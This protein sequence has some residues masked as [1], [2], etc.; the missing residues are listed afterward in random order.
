MRSIRSAVRHYIITVI[1]VDVKTRYQVRNGI[2][3]ILPDFN[4]M[5]FNLRNSFDRATIEE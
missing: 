2:Q 1:S 5:N 4:S 3:R